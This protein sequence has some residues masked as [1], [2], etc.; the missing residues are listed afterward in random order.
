VKNSSAVLNSVFALAITSGVFWTLC[1]GLSNHLATPT[2]VAKKATATP[3]FPIPEE[4]KELEAKIS[5]DPENIPTL[6][7]FADKN[8]TLAKQSGEVAHL[9]RAVQSYSKVLNLNPANKDALFGMANLSFESGVFDKAR[10]YYERF[11]EVDPGNLKA[12]TDLSLVIL[13]LGEVEDATARLKRLSS[14]N[15]NYFPAKLSYA[16]AQKVGGDREGARV[17]ALE[18]YKISPD[19]DGK[20][21]VENFIASVDKV[22]EA[23]VPENVS[24]AIA[25]DQFFRQHPIV[26]PKLVQIRWTDAA[27]AEIKLKEFPMDKMPPFAKEKFLKSIESMLGA[28]KITLK[29]IDSE[30]SAVMETISH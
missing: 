1:S 6:I 9:M 3:A 17:T 16:L 25:V 26:G 27:T 14:E 13:Q 21:V 10:D 20:K 8:I 4:L 12:R 7:E 30:T 24:P 28:N 18:A 22:E 5:K 11:L 23:K 19:E 29:L 2:E 15:P